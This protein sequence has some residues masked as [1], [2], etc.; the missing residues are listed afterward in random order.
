M[1][2]LVQ[3]PRR[4]KHH[5]PSRRLPYA[6]QSPSDDRQES[7]RRYAPAFSDAV[8]VAHAVEVPDHIPRKR[9]VIT[10]HDETASLENVKGLVPGDAVDAEPM[11]ARHIGEVVA[12][13]VEDHDIRGIRESV[14]LENKERLIG[15][16]CG[17]TQV[18]D[19]SRA[20]LLGPNRIL[21]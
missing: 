19:L 18:Q 10:T 16:V 7:R 2:N 5:V 12:A 4:L 17:H 20:M 11:I 3:W 15:T 9:S 14:V 21:V 1:A 6:L 13:Q 8:L